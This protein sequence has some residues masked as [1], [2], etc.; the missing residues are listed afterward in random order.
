MITSKIPITILGQR[1]KLMLGFHIRHT[2]PKGTYRIPKKK[3]Q[4]GSLKWGL[5][6]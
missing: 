1:N 6:H 2:V 4:L 3:V 5:H